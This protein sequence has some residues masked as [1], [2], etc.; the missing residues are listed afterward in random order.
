MATGVVVR[1]KLNK[2]HDFTE[3]ELSIQVVVQELLELIDVIIRHRYTIP[4]TVVCKVS[5]SIE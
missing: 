1:V 5:Y 2:D 4:L 3:V